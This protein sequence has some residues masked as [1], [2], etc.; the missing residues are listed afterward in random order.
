MTMLDVE[1][2][3]EELEAMKRRAKINYFAET[4]FTRLYGQEVAR[5]I[6]ANVLAKYRHIRIDND[7]YFT[8]YDAWNSLPFETVADILFR[9][10]NKL[11]CS[12]KE[13]NSIFDTLQAERNKIGQLS[14]EVLELC[15]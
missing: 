10:I 5:V 13:S 11:P 7:K 3:T 2:S 6:V 4:F 9:A 1:Y 14:E 8:F 12:E 15:N